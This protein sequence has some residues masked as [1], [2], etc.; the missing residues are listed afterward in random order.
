VTSI[1]ILFINPSVNPY[2]SRGCSRRIGSGF[3]PASVQFSERS[4]I[5]DG[6]EIPSDLIPLRA[7]QRDSLRREL[8]S[9]RRGITRAPVLATLATQ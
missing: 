1:R 6:L 8:A 5:A 7:T 9:L 2:P 4:N 3:S